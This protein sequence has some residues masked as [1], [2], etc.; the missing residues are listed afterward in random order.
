MAQIPV[1]NFSPHPH[2]IQLGEVLGVA[3]NLCSWLDEPSAR[4]KA[5]AKKMAAFIDKPS[6]DWGKT[7]P[8]LGWEEEEELIGPKTAEVPE[9]ETLPSSNL[10]TIL[11][12]SPEAPPEIQCRVKELIRKHQGA[13][14]FHN[15][16][17]K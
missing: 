14:S 3:Q 1:A 10:A 5:E 4:A 12:V 16:L 9:S 7:K 2:I 13:F 17:G 15:S 11:G 6:Q 8:S